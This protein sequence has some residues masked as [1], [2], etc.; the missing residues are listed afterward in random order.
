M[1][2][3]TSCWKC[4]AD[5]AG[6]REGAKHCKKCGAPYQRKAKYEQ[7]NAKF[8]EAM[9]EIGQHGYAK[10]GDLPKL[11][12]NHC[13]PDRVTS[14]EIM[15]HAANHFAAYVYDIPHDHFN[16]RRHQLAAVAFNAMMEFQFACLENEQ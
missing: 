10:Y 11:R 13:N 3:P 15:Q 14:E 7:L 2:T 16:T 8:L 9:N 6:S 1:Q 5:Q 12:E 4:K